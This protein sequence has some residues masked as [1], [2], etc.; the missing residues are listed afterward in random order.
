ML[1]SIAS[2][3]LAS[4]G[5]NAAHAQTKVGVSIDQIKTLKETYTVTYVPPSTSVYA[6]RASG[7]TIF[8]AAI[9]HTLHGTR[10]IVLPMNRY[11]TALYSVIL[12]LPDSTYK[13]RLEICIPTDRVPE[14]IVE[15]GIMPNGGPTWPST[16][17]EN[18]PN[19]DSALKFERQTYPWNYYA[20]YQ[21]WEKVKPSKKDGKVLRTDVVASNKL[22][23]IIALVKSQ[24]ATSFNWYFTI[25]LLSGSRVGGDSTE[26]LYLD[27]AV[28]AQ[29]RDRTHEP[30]LEYSGFWN[31][32]YYPEMRD[33]EMVLQVERSVRMQELA[34]AYPRT[35][36]GKMWM[37]RATGF[38]R[39]DMQN[40][41]TMIDAWSTSYDVDVLSSIGMRLM[42]KATP[43]YDPVR[44]E[45]FFKRAELSSIKQIGFRTGENIFGSMGRVDR[46]R[47]WLIKAY[48][49]QG[50]HADAIALGEQSMR[51]AQNAFGRQKISEAQIEVALAMGDSTLAERYK[52]YELPALQDFAYT[53]LNGTAGKLAD[54]KGKVI[55]LDF[56]F[57]GCAG[58]ALEHKSLNEFGTK[59]N[60][61]PRVVFLSIALND[62]GVI[63]KYLAKSPL[64]AIVVAD[65][66]AICDDVGVTGFPTH[67]IIDKSG[68][69][70][71]WEVGSSEESG[72]QLGKVVEKLL[73]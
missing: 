8:C 9:I 23:S 6:T 19:A 11:D 50:R 46:I 13:V 47:S 41:W 52:H 72:E 22:D 28:T 20:L 29:L 49:A 71:L 57:V 73:K 26:H 70:V 44:A 21:Y 10:G 30:L 12:A 16:A 35:E 31:V 48:S 25:A 59:Y 32:F 63:D 38:D 66:Q 39:L 3:L 60:N 45:K 7:D 64:K 53:S 68:K 61:D 54:H 27:S 1:F 67:V 4:V 51:M 69:T 37:Q 43:A 62:K 55:V 15:F 2:V 24:P 17:M 18:M 36:F 34:A 33:G 65:G 56:W 42:I 40:F 58:C 14:G 5:I